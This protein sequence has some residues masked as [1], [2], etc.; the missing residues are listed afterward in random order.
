MVIV[1]L[2]APGCSQPRPQG[3]SP[4]LYSI[5][6]NCFQWSS[7]GRQ[8]LFSRDVPKIGSARGA[9]FPGAWSVS[10]PVHRSPKLVHNAAR[11]EY[12]YSAPSRGI[13]SPAII[14]S[15]AVAGPSRNPAVLHARQN[16][17]LTNA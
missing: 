1:V 16:S 4:C 17:I 8:R 6:W 5:V 7:V 9:R 10:P 11:T 3:F 2:E 12:S 13:K 14:N 15:P